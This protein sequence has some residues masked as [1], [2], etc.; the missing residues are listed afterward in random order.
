MKHVLAPTGEPLDS[1][2]LPTQERGAAAS[3][4]AYIP[5]SKEIH[6]WEYVNNPVISKTRTC[7]GASRS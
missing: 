2:N 3:F 4:F 7:D 1:L 6:C 5:N